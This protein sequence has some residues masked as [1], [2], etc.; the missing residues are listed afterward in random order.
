MLVPITLTTTALFLA[1]A[2]FARD[3]KDGQNF[4]TPVYMLLVLP[5][6]AT[7]LPGIEL[8]AW[9]AFVPVVNIALLLKGLL[10]SEAPLE[11]VF[12][13]SSPRPCSRCCPSCS[14]CASFSAS[15]CC[16]A[17]ASRPGRPRPGTTGGDC[18]RPRL[19]W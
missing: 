12:L 1:V 10:I 14:P 19:R 5:A 11:L 2:V 9:T 8:N 16:S 4:L 18:P 17:A 6:G 15:R 3:F 7:M 13:R